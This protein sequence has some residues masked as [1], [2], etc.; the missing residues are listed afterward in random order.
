MNKTLDNFGFG[1]SI[2]FVLLYWHSFAE[3]DLLSI[4]QIFG[5]TELNI[6]LMKSITVGLFLTQ[7]FMFGN[8]VF[9]EPSRSACYV[10]RTIGWLLILLGYLIFLLLNGG[11]DL[12]TLLRQ[13]G[14][15]INRFD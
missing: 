5:I 13:P 12:E 4:N 6:R 2:V 15:G 1:L 9:F 14:G 7:L 3:A 10:L 8:L 11:M